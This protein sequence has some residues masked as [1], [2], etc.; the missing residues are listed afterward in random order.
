MVII[1]SVILDFSF[2]F[3]RITFHHNIYY[4]IKLMKA[5]EKN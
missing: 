2:G 1:S 3:E 5:K 4:K